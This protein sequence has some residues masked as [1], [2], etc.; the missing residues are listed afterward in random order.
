M[1]R[2]SDPSAVETIDLGPCQ[3][4]G[5]PHERDEAVVRFQL[6][7]SALARIGRAELERS[8]SLD[9]YAAYRQTAVECLVSWNLVWEMGDAEDRR[10]MP[11][12]LIPATIA[13]LDSTTL[14]TIAETADK[15]IQGNGTLPNV[16]GAPSRASS[17]G[18]ASRGRKAILTPGT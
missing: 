12:P 4:P 9:P 14:T 3:C 2:L 13:E 17:R 1:S 8:V 6:S 11:V 16:S 15:L 5:K 18:S 10:V 7:G